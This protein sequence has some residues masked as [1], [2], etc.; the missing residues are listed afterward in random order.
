M[1][2]CVSGCN[3][4]FAAETQIVAATNATKR[5]KIEPGDSHGSHHGSHHA[6]FIVEEVER[7]RT[8]LSCSLPSAEVI[9]LLLSTESPGN[10]RCIF[11]FA[12]QYLHP[13]SPKDTVD[14]L[15]R[16]E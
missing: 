2:I 7:N 5:T 1:S 10:S 4:F 16:D 9:T 6:L 12:A 8:H 14:P 3:E 15:G 13:P 11:Q